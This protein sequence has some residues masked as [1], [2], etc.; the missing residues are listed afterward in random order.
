M[1]IKAHLAAAYSANYA[2]ACRVMGILQARRCWS[3]N[4]VLAVARGI[5]LLRTPTIWSDLDK[6]IDDVRIRDFVE[7]VKSMRS[8]PEYEK[9]VEVQ[10]NPV[11]GTLRAW[12]DGDLEHSANL[13]DA[14]SQEAESQEGE[15]QEAETERCPKICDLWRVKGSDFTG[16]D[17]IV[18]VMLYSLVHTGRFPCAEGDISRVLVQQLRVPALAQ[19]EAIALW[20]TAHDINRS[21]STSDGSHLASLIQGENAPSSEMADAQVG[22]IPR[23]VR[24]GKRKMREAQALLVERANEEARAKRVK[25]SPAAAVEKGSVSDDDDD[26]Q[27]IVKK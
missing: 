1:M 26:V 7:A 4:E 3:F 11:D 17:P 6:S 20:L 12:L 15:S 10:V 13:G 22:E 24:E 9:L 27:E 18:S 5:I 23:A 14:E 25:A 8:N 2:E 19:A 16:G 21:R